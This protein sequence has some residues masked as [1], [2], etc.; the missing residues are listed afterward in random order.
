MKI[1]VARPLVGEEEVEAV[2][3]VMRSGMLAQGSVVTEFESR[4]ADY[5]G[6]AHA[7]GVNSG[8]AALHAA[9]LAAGIGPGDSVVVPAFTFFATASSVSMC[10]ATPLFADVDPETFNI[11]PDSVAALIRPDT[12]AVIGVHLFGQPFDVGSVREVCDDHNL[13][14]IEDAAQAHGAEYHGKRAGSLADLACFSFYPTKNMTTS[15][16]GMVTTDDDALAERV[17]LLINHG[18]SR[19]YLH[20]VIGYNYRMTNIDAA[21]GLVQLG[22]L[23]G[24]NERRRKNARYLDRHLAGTGLAT[25]CV[26]PGVRHVYH[27]YVVKVPGDYALSRDAFMSALADRGIGTAVHYPIPVNRQPVYENERASC[28]VSDDLAA[29]VVSLPV[30][31]AVTDEDLAY[32]RDTVRGLP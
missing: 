8:T 21:I 9:L 26:A 3:R 1:P 24:F 7:V 27:Q 10:G 14:L 11:D 2:A 18:Q 17:R 5:C 29:S 23:E 20:T 15:E 31:P 32:I 6:A 28:P 4:F 12:R 16:G 19:K 30:H 13:I 22:R 25:P